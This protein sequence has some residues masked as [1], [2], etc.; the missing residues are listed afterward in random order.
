M[1]QEFIT[2]TGSLRGQPPILPSLPRNY[3][4][5]MQNK[6]NFLETQMNIN[7]DMTKHY[8]NFHLLG[9]RKNKANSNPI[10]P[11]FT[12]YLLQEKLMPKPLSLSIIQIYQSIS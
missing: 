10:K 9:R 7:P 12:N 1:T 8:G 5:F 2:M 4:L 6:P 11:N 3:T